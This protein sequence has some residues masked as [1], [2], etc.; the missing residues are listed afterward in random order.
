MEWN[1]RTLNKLGKFENL[2]A[3]AT[4]LDVDILGISE[5]RMIGDGKWNEGEYVFINSGKDK[6]HEYGVGMAIKKDLVKYNMGYWPINER[7]IALTIRAKP[8]NIFIL[9]CY[10]PT[11][12]HPDEEAEI[13][14]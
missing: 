14:K 8:F 3:E 1:V 7:I 12:D 2:I 4:A 9:Q 11:T 13:N 10:A 5:T 6:T